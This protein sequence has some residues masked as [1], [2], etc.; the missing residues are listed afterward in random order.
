MV[1]PPSPPGPPAPVWRSP[2]V[3][4]RC[5][6]GVFNFFVADTHVGRA[7]GLYGEYS[8]SEVML[9]Q[10]LLTPGAVVVEAGANIGALTV[11]I[12]NR[13]GPTGRVMAYEP[14]AALADL[15]ARTATANALGQ[16]EVRHAALGAQP[17]TTVVP[18]VNY[19]ASGNFGSVGLGGAEGLTVPVETLDD[20]GL[21]RLDLIKVDVEGMELEVLAGATV[22]IR[23]LRP[24]LYLE[25]DRAER[26]RALILAL[27][28][29]GY[30]AWWHF[31]GLFNPANYFGNPEN[32]FPDMLSVNLLCF[33]REWDMTVTNG[34][35]V[36]GPDADWESARRRG[37]A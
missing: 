24:M 8:E 18:R 20:L 19:L 36:L 11:P 9:F 5:R 30:R 4:K 2:I 25:N 37:Q 14:Q 15:L 7:L 13:V 16:I 22:S 33:P 12:A 28:D 26:S 32:V 34:I 21:A 27:D 10:Q 17:G 31:A 29:L 35:P 23:R 1:D 6:H 3:V